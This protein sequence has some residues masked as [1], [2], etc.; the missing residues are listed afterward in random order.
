MDKMQVPDHCGRFASTDSATSN[1]GKEDWQRITT[2]VPHE[3]ICALV[4]MWHRPHDLSHYAESTLVQLPSFP[5]KAN[6]CSTNGKGA[7]TKGAASRMCSGLYSKSSIKPRQKW[8]GLV[9]AEHCP[10][11][12]LVQLTLVVECRMTC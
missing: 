10:A 11:P 4:L 12:Q 2:A 3:P 9:P 7:G 1:P 5:A 6:I 8:L